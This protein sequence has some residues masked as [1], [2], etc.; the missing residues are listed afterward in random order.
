[1]GGVLFTALPGLLVI[2]GDRFF[3]LFLATA[4]LDC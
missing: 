2:F 1:M 3:I 4:L